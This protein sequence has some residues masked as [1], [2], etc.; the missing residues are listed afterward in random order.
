MYSFIQSFTQYNSI[1]EYIVCDD[2]A[3]ILQNTQY[4]NYET[5]NTNRYKITL[6]C[7]EGWSLVAET[8]VETFQ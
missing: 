1:T 3:I 6:I 7:K 2:M 8:T 5:N 4:D